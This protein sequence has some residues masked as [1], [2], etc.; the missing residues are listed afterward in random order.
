MLVPVKGVSSLLQRVFW[1][2]GF[3]LG[4]A[5]VGYAPNF[6]NFHPSPGGAAQIPS[7]AGVR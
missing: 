4:H 6:S 5:I 2:T 7:G 3:G 1:A